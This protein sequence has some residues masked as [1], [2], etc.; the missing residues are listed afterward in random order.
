MY[1]S[2]VLDPLYRATIPISGTDFDGKNLTTYT[3]DFWVSVLACADRFQFRNPANGISTSLTSFSALGKETNSLRLTKLQLAT[4]RSLYYTIG[5]SIT[6]QTVQSRG[7]NSLRASDVVSGTDHLSPGLPDNQW[8]IEATEL[9]S[10]SM[11][12]LQQQI[13]GYA[14]GPT[15]IHEGM[16]F[17]QGDKDLCQR[18]K[19]RGVSG[20]LSFSVLGVSIILIL[21]CLFIIT[22]LVLDSTVG[23]FRRKLDWK[24]HKRLQ[25]AV[26]EKLQIQR[27]AF[28]GAGHGTWT[29][30]T[31]AVPKT[32][33]DDW[34]LLDQNPT[35][36]T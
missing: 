36:I 9:F 8:Q 2:P 11:A 12:K 18:Q 13:I 29:G 22:A 23:F 16:H 34:L 14:T 5:S 17:T 20:Y 30:G 3:Q 28:E 4:V 1:Q 26:D 15:Y 7:A 35:S 24:D 33:A 32:R 19:I 21:G 25:W 6:Y 10:V 31:D 27:L